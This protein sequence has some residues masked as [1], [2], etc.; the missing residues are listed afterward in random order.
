MNDDLRK[1]FLQTGDAVLRGNGLEQAV[2]PVVEST[3]PNKKQ[4]LSTA[5]EQKSTA[6]PKQQPFEGQ[7]SKKKSRGFFGWI[8]YLIKWVI[9]II[10]GF[11]ALGIYFSYSEE[12]KKYDTPTESTQNQLSANPTIP[13]TA[14]PDPQPPIADNAVIPLAPPQTPREISIDD[15]YAA[16]YG[17][18][19]P[20]RPDPNILDGKPIPFIGSKHE[21]SSSNGR[22]YLIFFGYNDNDRGLDVLT[23]INNGSGWQQ[24]LKTGKFTTGYGNSSV[25]AFLPLPDPN[26]FSIVSHR[27]GVLILSI[28]TGS[29]HGKK[30]ENHQTT[31]LMKI[32]ENIQKAMLLAPFTRHEY[33]HESVSHFKE[34]SI[35]GG[36]WFYSTIK[37][38]NWIGNDF[39]S[40]TGEKS[41]S[42]CNISTNPRSNEIIRDTCYERN[43]PITLDAIKNQR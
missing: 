4:T 21:I 17:D 6:K 22:R 31:R 39:Y 28:R 23:Y 38:A 26:A 42:A 32:D 5:T 27:D 33:S 8:W 13:A 16:L 37:T 40:S 25:S 30:L 7:P 34:V 1:K 9:A 10:I 29:I 2:V 14:L 19:V 24:L 3:V 41:S 36:L 20:S 43:I 15:A 18:I 35:N 12:N 11:I